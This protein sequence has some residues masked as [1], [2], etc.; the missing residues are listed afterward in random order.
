LDVQA[1]YEWLVDGAPG[2][3][4]AADVMGTLSQRLRERGLPIDRAEAFVRTLHPHIVGRSFVWRPDA[5]TEVFEQSYAYLRSPEFVASPVAEVFA[6]GTYARHRLGAADLAALPD[7]RR[8]Y[9]Q[10]L[11]EQGYTD[12]YAAP[13]RFRSGQVHAITFATRAPEGFTE[14]HL[15]ATRRVMPPLSR[16]AEILA[17]SRTAVN[18]LNTYVGRNAGERIL[19]GQIQ[20]GDVEPISAVIWFSDLRG[21]TAL[22]DAVSP[23]ELIR[24]LNELFECQVPAIEQRGGEV[25]KFIGDGLLAIFP[26][27][28]G[29]DPLPALVEN[30]LAAA[31]DAFQ[32]LAALNARRGGDHLRFGLALH[33]GEI[34]YGNIG[35]SGRLD[36]TAI[37]PA[38][39]V[40]S[41]LEGLTSKLGVDIVA[42]QEIA[43]LTDRPVRDLGV[44]ELKGVA[45]SA[46]VFAIE[47]RASSGA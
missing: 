21:F 38:V 18:L 32:A 7:E 47:P 39:N 3:A 8:P 5:P 19:G 46:R 24:A 1:I 20:R 22:S 10:R 2:S 16:V 11:A 33:M 23:G 6:S 25:L 4:S 17:L 34:V 28:P 41:R 42:S 9:L 44:F 15:A 35:G 29:G 13:M 37:G 36:F 26:I 43:A 27:V 30:A 40:A 14:D 31:D 45:S 12:F